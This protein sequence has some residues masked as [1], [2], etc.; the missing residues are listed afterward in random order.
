[1]NHAISR[2]S[3]FLPLVVFPLTK[4]TKNKSH[5]RNF[6]PSMRLFLPMVYF[7][8]ARA[9]AGQKVPWKAEIFLSLPYYIY[10][11]SLPLPSNSSI[12]RHKRGRTKDHVNA[13][14]RAR[15]GVNSK[16]E[17]PRVLYG[18][19][20]PPLVALWRRRRALALSV[21]FQLTRSRSLFML[22][23]SRSLSAESFISNFSQPLTFCALVK[24]R[25]RVLYICRFIW[26][27]IYTG[28]GPLMLIKKMYIWG[29]RERELACSFCCCARRLL[30]KVYREGESE[31]RGRT[32]SVSE[33][34]KGINKLLCVL[35]WIFS[36]KNESAL[37]LDFLIIL[38]M[39]T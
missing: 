28:R 25:L 10:L 38:V 16:A 34:R 35:C 21:G 39:S 9:R 11:F 14:A 37:F 24:S 32:W 33:E 18:I 13:D 31:G 6:C 26:S 30:E 27:E 1:M 5:A 17:L 7:K 23:R 4:I 29:R 3:L 12:R 36:C 22:S 2:P 15:E 8:N 20:S 19:F